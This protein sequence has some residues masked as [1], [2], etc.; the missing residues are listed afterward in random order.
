MRAWRNIDGFEGRSALRTWVYRIATS[1][2][3]PE[4]E[5]RRNPPAP[6]QDSVLW[7]EPCPCG[8]P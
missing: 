3:W 2:C 7:V 5:R 8:A 1:V 6:P 4:R